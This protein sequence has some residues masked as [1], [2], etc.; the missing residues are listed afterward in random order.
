MW[1]T[2]LSEKKN[3]KTWTLEKELKQK[4][5]LESICSIRSETAN[6][7]LDKLMMFDNAYNIEDRIILNIHLTN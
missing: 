4:K 2:Y 1:T 5:T 3:G 6:N 7:S